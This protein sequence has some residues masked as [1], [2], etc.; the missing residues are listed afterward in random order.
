M[1]T[2]DVLFDEMRNI[3]G[4]HISWVELIIFSQRKELF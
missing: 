1:F 2:S 4:F 3:N